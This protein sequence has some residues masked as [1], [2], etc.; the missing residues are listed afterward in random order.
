LKV[1]ALMAENGE[2]KK[3]NKRLV[4]QRRVAVAVNP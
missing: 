1:E 4:M 2:V 3:E